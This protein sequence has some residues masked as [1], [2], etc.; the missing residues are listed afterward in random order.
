MA[1]VKPV[2]ELVNAPVVPVAVTLVSAVVGFALMLYT[3][4]LSVIVVPPS[5]V[6]LPPLDAVVAV[7]LL[8]AVVVTVARVSVVKLTSLP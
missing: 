6:T 2:S 8:A 7:I 4:P 3:I 1:G 5:L